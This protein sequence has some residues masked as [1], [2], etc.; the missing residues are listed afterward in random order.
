MS[1]VFTV[2]WSVL[3]IAASRG[4]IS[5]LLGTRVA[6]IASVAA[7][8]VG[9]AVGLVVAEA[10][11]RH[12]HRAALGAAFAVSSSLATLIAAAGLGLFAR[13]RPLSFEHSRHASFGH[14]LR[15]VR[16]RFDR[17][18]RYWQL[19]RVA[20]RHGLGPLALLHP[21]RRRSPT[22]AGTALRDAL[23]DAGGIFVKFGQVLSTR[24]DLVSPTVAQALSSLQDQVRAVPVADVRRVIEDELGRSVDDLFAS[25]D[26]EPLAAASLAQVHVARLHSGQAVVV[27]VQRPDVG[28]LVERDLQILLKVAADG[29]DGTGWA[30]QMG[31]AALARGFAAN[32]RQELDF[33][34]EADHLALIRAAIVDC[35]AIRIPKP[36]LELTTTRVLVEDRIAGSRLSAAQGRGD[37][38][39]LS[40]AARALLEAFLVQLLRVGVF[41]ADPHPGNIV[42]QPGGTLGLLDFGSVGRLDPLQRRALAQALVA[43]ARRQPRLL[44]D[45]LL[46]LCTHD[47]V[48]DQEAFDRHLA[49]FLSDRFDHGVKIGAEALGDL[50][51]LI[52]RFGLAVDAELA[53]MFRAL[54]TLDGTLQT[55][56]PGFD[57]FVEAQRI[58][59]QRGLISPHL[60]GSAH[61]I[62]DDLLEALPAL[63]RLP[64]RLDQIGQLT[65]RGEL[66][67]RV[68][69]FGDRRDADHIDQLANRFILAL[70]SGSVGVVSALLVTFTGNNAI[71]VGHT[72]LNQV[73]GY[74]GLTAATLL[75]LRVVA[76]IGRD[77]R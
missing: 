42:V 6:L 32:L 37:P 54:A 72:P 14:P 70:I 67:L 45:A 65:E 10:L 19:L 33:R 35:P 7:A 40:G 3:L 23:Q 63:R 11:S 12:V 38:D 22:D 52:L 43:L 16:G 31:V 15:I 49:R 73:I 57:L 44:R 69:L 59:R 28:P 58:A 13:S 47:D 24:S 29:E 25:F 64:R 77:R 27:K 55:M 30:R 76:A 1:V 8:G 71:A 46:E 66:T 20:A 5:R 61:D 75:G 4:A 74:A 56:S 48:I 51:E 36:Y 50:L 34:A 39:E 2:V 68:R 60:S 18:R 17:A 53:G 62:G 21:I 26:D 9:I 41:H